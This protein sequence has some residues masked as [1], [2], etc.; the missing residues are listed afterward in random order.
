M[1]ITQERNVLRLSGIPTTAHSISLL[2]EATNCNAT[3]RISETL[4]LVINQ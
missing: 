4:Q 2:L 3:A 1:N